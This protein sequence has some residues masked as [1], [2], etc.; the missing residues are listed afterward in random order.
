M[1][2]RPLRRILVIEDEPDLRA[3]LELCLQQVGGFDTLLCASGE[4]ALAR[5]AAFRPDLLLLD[6]MMPGL[7]GPT[8]LDRLR[9]RGMDAPAFFLTAKVH[10]VEV[11]ELS[12]RGAAAVVAKPFDPMTLARDLRAR[13][14][15][16]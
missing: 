6:V 13:W 4:E 14:E 1:N 16:L 7:D 12:A 2:G 10:P 8:T 11:A 3:V 15:A 9:L 5:G